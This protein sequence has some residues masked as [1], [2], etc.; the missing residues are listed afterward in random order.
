MDI[1]IDLPENYLSSEVR[2]GFRVNEKR[3]KIWAVELDLLNEFATICEKHNLSY[4]LDGG[5]L[6][7]A[8]RHQGFIPWDDDVDV[9]MPRKD[10]DRLVEIAPE[11][12]KEPYFFQTSLST[13]GFFRTHAQLR[14][15]STTGFIAIDA[16]KPQVNKGIWLDIFPRDNIPDGWF[17]KKWQKQRIKLVKT[18][19]KMKY[20][21]PANWF[22]KL[23]YKANSFEKLF[24]Y[25]DQRVLAC[26]TNKD[27]KWTGNVSLSWQDKWIWPKAYFQDYC[28]LKFE[29]LSFRVPVFYHEVLKRQYGKDY[30]LFPEGYLNIPENPGNGKAMI[31][32]HT[33]FEPDT[34]Y[35]EYDFSKYLKNKSNI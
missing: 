4:F 12:F 23:Y 22:A 29:T 17:A 34:P 24:K 2:C 26:Y 5:T 25:F 27:T 33:I 3:K 30:M 8:V 31:H 19:L 7:G 28:Y 1:K 11:E 14:N 13:K 10:Y 15:S 6:L 18:L 16:T 21:I 20:D 32:G 9:N 35:A